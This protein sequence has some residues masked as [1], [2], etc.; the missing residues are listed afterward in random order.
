MKYQERVERIRR[1]KRL[2]QFEWRDEIVAKLLED[3][4]I[5]IAG[6][7]HYSASDPTPQSIIL[8]RGEA[9]ELSKWLVDVYGDE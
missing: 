3:D 4:K 1:I 6:G 2:I 8:T 5:V 9:A 7:R